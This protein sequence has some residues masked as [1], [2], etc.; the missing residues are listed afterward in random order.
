MNKPIQPNRRSPGRRTEDK[1]HRY[2]AFLLYTLF[3]IASLVCV[4]YYAKQATI[5][6]QPTYD[7]SP[8]MS[9]KINTILIDSKNI[10]AIHV[11]AVNLK[12]NTR[13]VVRKFISDDKLAKLNAKLDNGMVYKEI[14]F[15]TE[16]AAFNSRMVK[17]LNHEFVCT[18]F[19]EM[20]LYTYSPEMATVISTGCT[21]SVPPEYGRFSGII[22]IFLKS[23]PTE[24]EQEQMRASIYSIAHSLDSELRNHR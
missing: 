23:E 3:T 13:I 12:N 9:A 8:A 7:L 1:L 14:P 22:N 16:D 4:Y 11:T 15:F 21:M 19:K 10:V 17:V 6:T 24:I 5:P 18:P 2:A 20:L